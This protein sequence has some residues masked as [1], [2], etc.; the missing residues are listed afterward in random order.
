[1][2]ECT[3]RQI[4]RM[5]LAYELGMTN[6]EDRRKVEMHLLECPAC[7]ERVK[8]FQAM[9][10]LMRE[11]QDARRAMEG[12]AGI[13]PRPKPTHHRE[14]RRIGWN[15]SGAGR[16][17]AVAAAVIIVFLV[18][19]WQL[20]IRPGQKAV[21]AENKLLILPF[22]DHR[23]D[24]ALG[25]IVTAL[26]ITDLSESDY[27]QV[28]SREILNDLPRVVQSEAGLTDS[29]DL[30]IKM[31]ERMNSRWVLHGEVMRDQG[32]TIITSRLIDVS[33]SSPVATQTVSGLIDEPIF[34]LVDRLTTEVK[35]D[36]A[37]PSQALEELD[38][39]VADVTTHFPEAYV[40]FLEGVDYEQKFYTA[41]A[42]NAFERCLEIDSTFAMAYYH[43]SGL[44]DRE[45]IR[46]AVKY[47]DRVSQKEKY[48]IQARAAEFLENGE[49][50]ERILGELLDRYP[51]EAEALYLLGLHAYGKR[52]FHEAVRRW[53]E[54]LKIDPLYKSAYNQLSYSYDAIGLLDKAVEAINNY[55]RIAPNE[56][57][58]YDSRGDLYARNG[59]I[60]EAIRSYQ[61]ALDKKPDF[62]ASI[63]NLGHMYLFKG[64]YTEALDLYRAA[65]READGLSITQSRM[66]EA[67]IP[68][69]RGRLNEALA[70]VD[71]AIANLRTIAQEM[72]VPPSAFPH[73][74][75]AM[76]YNE[77]DRLG[78]AVSE[79]ETCIRITNEIN[80]E[81]KTSYRWMLAYYLERM[82]LHE[83]ADSII[84]QLHQ[85]YGQT[86]SPWLVYY[87]ATGM[88]AGVRG[89]RAT[90]VSMLEHAID[91]LTPANG[92]KGYCELGRANLEAGRYTEAIR[93]LEQAAGTY[94]LQ[95]VHDGVRG[96]KVHYWLGRAYEATGQPSRAVEQYNA[97]LRIWSEADTGLIEVDDARKRLGSL[98]DQS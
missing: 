68:M 84:D 12:L 6:D 81:N 89:D 78:E 21:A 41:E 80:P 38:P 61:A 60:D 75:K 20:D 18:I 49:G 14:S 77:Q 5:L 35:L 95:R 39:S 52:D 44:K 51:G 79:V 27:V 83:R 85:Y 4:Q 90:E 8:R 59:L 67:L 70:A 7:F 46:K 28:I 34:S 10:S 45:L 72:T 33:T 16:I 94:G 23:T 3:D 62:R 36:L 73:Y 98:K 64:R 11:D 86:S 9:S 48:Y 40:H 2:T 53:A 96:V 93:L 57:N 88:V 37:L 76:I 97:F 31:G 91:G 82:G 13:E 58:P 19:P 54:V 15:W 26:L 92:Y 42:V 32:S 69:R 25:D 17:A 63:E 65:V 47:T 55:I 74:I 50:F 22:E 66:N 87:W 56:A 71:Q 30:I 43:L 24:T 29:T 1:M